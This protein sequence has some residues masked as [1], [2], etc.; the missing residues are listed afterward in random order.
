M[1]SEKIGKSL[2][3][4]GSEECGHNDIDRQIPND[5]IDALVLKACEQGQ[6]VYIQG[7]KQCDKCAYHDASVLGLTIVTDM[8]I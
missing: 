4:V 6:N 8:K 7:S 1:N 5:K 2:V 3:V